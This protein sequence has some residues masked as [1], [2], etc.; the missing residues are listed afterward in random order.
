MSHVLTRA[1]RRTLLSTAGLALVAAATGLLWSPG[2]V[3]GYTPSSEVD[4]I[5]LSANGDRFLNYDG[6]KSFQFNNRDWP[7]TMIFYTNAT[8]SK[9]EDYYRSRGFSGHGGHM[10]EYYAPHTNYNKVRKDSD[11]GVKTPCVDGLDRHIRVYGATQDRFYDPRY[12][13]YVVASTHFD[14]GDGDSGAC[15]VDHFT[16]KYFG[17]SETVAHDLAVIAQGKWT[18][19]ENAVNLKNVESPAR[20]ESSPKDHLHWWESDGKATL[21]SVP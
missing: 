20:S 6:Q 12:G 21:V 16:D 9:V 1:G 13:Y 17:Y 11:K 4:F 8:I 18:V 7:I 19:N 15:H 3:K 2:G 10:Y 14:N 5:Q